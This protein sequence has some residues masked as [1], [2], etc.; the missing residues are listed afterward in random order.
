VHAKKTSHKINLPDRTPKRH[1]T[2]VLFTLIELLVVISIIALL[3][4]LLLPALTMAR[5]KG[6]QI[7]CANNLRNW[8]Q[9]K[10]FYVADYN[11]WLYNP[12]ASSANNTGWRLA[13]YPYLGFKKEY[14]YPTLFKGSASTCPSD[15]DP[16][17][18]AGISYSS[19][20]DNSWGCWA[21]GNYFCI[22]LNSIEKPS[23][24]FSMG[25]SS[26]SSYMGITCTNIHYI[27]FRHNAGLNMLFC[28]GHTEYKKAKD[29]TIGRDSDKELWGPEYFGAWTN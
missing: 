8:G 2:S 24:L 16:I 22:R 4:S 26:G 27:S 11:G 12:K 6:K 3:A 15:P 10:L 1:K 19:Y 17:C 9:A 25:D 14:S 18:T 7:R 20:G 23:T 29:L 28:D 21:L 5:E 13:L